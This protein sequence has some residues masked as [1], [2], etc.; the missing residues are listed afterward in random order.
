[1]ERRTLVFIALGVIV[2]VIA[3]ILF[4]PLGSKTITVPQQ[5]EQ[6]VIVPTGRTVGNEIILTR[7]F[8]SPDAMTI[9]QGDRLILEFMSVG[10]ERSISAPGL[11]VTKILD[12]D[13][14]TSITTEAL[15]PGVITF[16]CTSGCDAGVSMTVTVQ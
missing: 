1:M 7:Q 6:E 5:E 16:Y 3:T 8:F 14:A 12:A 2:L 9:K 13:T 15:A 4:A 10:V 11:G